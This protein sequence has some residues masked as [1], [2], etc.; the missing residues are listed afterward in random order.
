MA[1]KQDV[2]GVTVDGD[3]TGLKRAMNEATKEMRSAARSIQN[4]NKAIENDPSNKN[5]IDNRINTYKKGIDEAITALKNLKKMRDDLKK[6]EN[7]NENT[8]TSEEYTSLLKQITETE[9]KLKNLREEYKQVRDSAQQ[10]FEVKVDKFFEAMRKSTEALERV[11]NKLNEVNQSIELDP[12]NIDLYVKK[13]Q[14]LNEAVRIGENQL[15]QYHKRLAE[16]KSNPDYINGYEELRIEFL[17]VEKQSKQLEQ[18]LIN[19]KKQAKDSPELARFKQQFVNLGDAFKT[20]GENTRL[21][22]KAFQTLITASFHSFTSMESDIANIK[23][24]VSDLSESTISDLKEIA[25]QTGTTFNE[26][27]EYATIAGAL[28][29]AEKEI[30]G[31][32]KTMTD[33]NVATGGAFKGEEGAKGIAV[34]LKQLNLSI[35]QAENFGS[36]VAVI[37]D[38]YADIGDETV[39]VATKLSGLNTIIHTNQYELLGLAGV[40]SDLGL[41]ADSNANAI[42]RAFLQL[43]N[44]VAS[45]GT[46]LETLAKTAGMTSD[47][48]VKAWGGNAVDAFLSFIDGLDSSVFNEINDAIATSDE[49][50]QEYADTLGWSADLFRQ[51]WGEDS[52]KVFDLYVEKLSEL[53]EG[54]ESASKIL[55]ELGMSSVYTAQTLLRLSGSGNEVRRAIQLANEAWTENTALQ[56]KS[57][58]IYDTT[59]RKLQGVY[60]SLKQLGGSIVENFA[61]TITN[62]ID[63][64][65]E[66]LNGLKDMGPTAQT[67]AGYFAVFGATISPVSTAMSKLIGFFTLGEDGASKFGK[68]IDA[69][70]S[71]FSLSNPVGLIAGVVALGGALGKLA[72][73]R[74]QEAV[75]EYYGT[76]DELKTGLD[77]LHTSLSESSQEFIINEANILRQSESIDGMIVS[78]QNLKVA[79]EDTTE[80]TDAIKEAVSRLN[81]S[82][83]ENKFHFDETKGAI[84]DEQG[85]VVKLTNLYPDLATERKKSYYLE[86]YQS[87]YME[88]L[89]AEKKAIEDRILKHY[90]FDQALVSTSDEVRKLYDIMHNPNLS[91]AQKQNIMSSFG[92]DTQLAYESLEKLEKQLEEYEQKANDT[93]EHS[94]LIIGSYESL[95]NATV[96]NIDAVLNSLDMETQFT[97][98]EELVN[99][100]KEKI[101]AAYNEIQNH[102]DT[103]SKKDIENLKAQI[104]QWEAEIK[105]IEENRKAVDEAYKNRREK[106]DSYTKHFKE[107]T[108]ERAKAYGLETVAFGENAD[109]QAKKHGETV[110]AMDKKWYEYYTEQDKQLIEFTKNYNDSLTGEDGLQTK[111]TTFLDVLKNLWTKWTDNTGSY[112]SSGIK[113]AVDDAKRYAESTSI[114]VRASVQLDTSQYSRAISQLTNA[115]A[116]SLIRSSGFGVSPFLMDKNNLVNNIHSGGIG[117]TTN[118]NVYNNGTPIDD[119]VVNHW[120]DMIADKVDMVLGR[121]I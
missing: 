90:E 79:Q 9:E 20:V 41:S 60:E 25:V 3:I 117:V 40:M 84:V 82:L 104:E 10:I 4:I 64:V 6:S 12:N 11:R 80:Q 67:L 55:K 53:D 52:R 76:I 114:T 94:K 35:D 28:G 50:V 57:S 26:I 103:L 23:R 87:L 88:A 47:E 48:F 85:E 27:S 98:T 49:R 42:N 16:L 24:V 65:T 72:W 13:Q 32:A 39:N 62:L 37:G 5:L 2:F 107:K 102:S 92:R 58:L 38:R 91:D 68:T 59:A 66:L 51:K 120:V 14:L 93:I 31:F 70:S 75:K 33:L 106:V 74:H 54:G 121:K 113:G 45:G 29:L 105:V 19:L 110:D 8:E 118:I 97:S 44:H 115:S 22:S 36:A 116:S 63:T 95:A 100:L 112:V 56:D 71:I 119:N 69:L 78:L 101:S 18:D 111:T 1:R 89:E 15:A 34:F 77:E 86:H 81:E 96:E 17:E 99:S 43:N 83:G 109:E 46:K 108:E 7:F 21:L 73:D 30:S 61:P